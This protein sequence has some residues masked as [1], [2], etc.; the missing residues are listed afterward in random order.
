MGQG[1]STRGHA[2]EAGPGS[3]PDPRALD[4]V[5][6]EIMERSVSATS[7][8]RRKAHSERRNTARREQAPPLSVRGPG[9]FAWKGGQNHLL[10]KNFSSKAG[11][12]PTK[13]QKPS[14]RNFSTTISSSS[15]SSNSNS[16]SKHPGR[17]PAFRRRT[18]IA[19]GFEAEREEQE[20]Q[21]QRKRSDPNGGDRDRDCGHGECDDECDDDYDDGCYGDE[22]LYSHFY[23]ASGD[24][25]EKESATAGHPPGI[26]LE[27]L[28]RLEKGVARTIL[29]E[30]PTRLVVREREGGH[31]ARRGLS[32]RTGRGGTRRDSSTGRGTG[33][34]PVVILPEGHCYERDRDYFRRGRPLGDRKEG[35]DQEDDEDEDDASCSSSSDSDSSCSDGK[36]VHRLHRATTSAGHKPR[37]ESI[38]VYAV[39][40]PR[41]AGDKDCKCEGGEGDGEGDGS[42]VSGDRAGGGQGEKGSAER[43]REQRP[44]PRNRHPQQQP[45]QQQQQQIEKQPQPQPQQ[46]QSPTTEEP[47][48]SPTTPSIQAGAAATG[49]DPT[50][51]GKTTAGPAA[52]TGAKEDAKEDA[53]ANAGTD[54]N[55]NANANAN[56]G[57]NA[58]GQMFSPS[59]MGE[60]PKREVLDWVTISEEHGI[61]VADL[62]MSPAQCDALVTTTEQA[63]KG[64][65]AAYTYAKQT[66]GCREYPAL[67]RAV[68]S[69]VHSMVYAIT[70]RFRGE[71]GP[72]GEE[73]DR[74][75]AA[76]AKDGGD[77]R[78]PNGGTTGGDAPAGALDSAEPSLS[79]PGDGEP[80]PP[81]RVLQLDEREPHIVKYDVTKKERQKL[82]MHTDKSEF[83]FLI[84]LSNGC[85][86]DYDGGGTYFECLDATVHIQ[87]GHALVFPGKLRHRGTKITRGLRFLLVGFLV[88]KPLPLQASDAPA[89]EKT[90]TEHKPERRDAGGD[91][92]P[93]EGGSPARTVS[94]PAKQVL[95]A[96]DWC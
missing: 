41:E 23:A 34:P 63:C 37:R 1:C 14:G 21:Q 83:T 29:S 67:A 47:R 65:Y 72:P 2:V 28:E 92:F 59:R 77:G 32:W 74:E 51:P 44:L 10:Y 9:L 40:F 11:S 85:G 50:D 12:G 25:I 75:E 45:Q 82:D 5:M 61:Y 71:G 26:L 52:G 86:M 35:E 24:R 54:A 18:R 73:N 58:V 88:D 19:E 93:A 66:L 7:R 53:G 80:R 3:R 91:A 60:P 17:Q 4:P 70:Q 89:E 84:A 8:L 42:A 36:G 20:K 78:P 38:H 46:P 49:T 90:K 22:S 76:E 55:A 27:D 39:R 57:T 56:A 16:N 96:V 30:C 48:G 6:R 69:P 68:V 87:R 79:R 15:N 43:G 81:A 62:G 31:H 94:Q 95:P 13:K 64:H 33:S